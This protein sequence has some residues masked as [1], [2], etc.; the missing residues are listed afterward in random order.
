MGRLNLSQRPMLRCFKTTMT[1]D[2]DDSNESNAGQAKQGPWLIPKSGR[3]A[4]SHH[5]CPG[6][7]NAGRG[8]QSEHTHPSFVF[9]EDD[10]GGVRR[11]S[12][13]FGWKS[14]LRESHAVPN[15]G[16]IAYVRAVSR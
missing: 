2:A 3:L 16:R 13:G 15:T 4:G 11:V 7:N 1:D 8:H 9:C 10:A 14:Q 5:Q 6:R 12:V